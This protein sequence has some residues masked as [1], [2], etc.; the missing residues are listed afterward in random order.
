MKRGIC[1]LLSILM[2]CSMVMPVFAEEVM[3]NPPEVISETTVTTPPVP[4]EPTAT[5]TPVTPPA[6]TQC[7]HSWDAGSGSDATCTAAGTKTFTCTLCGGTKT[8]TTPARGHSYSSWAQVG[9]SSH[10]RSCSVC[11]AEETAAHGMTTSVTK[12]PTCVEKGTKTHSCS[13][14]GYSYTEEVAATGTHAYS[15]WT[16]TGEAHSCTCT[17]CGKVVSGT[18]NADGGEVTTPATCK[19][20]GI[21]MS[22]CT[23]C[24]Y[25]I[26]E[27]IPK[28]TEHTYDSVCDPDCNVCGVTRQVEH[29]LIPGWSKN[30]SGHWRACS[31]KGC[32]LQL[33]FGKHYPGPA[34]TEEEAQLC[35]TCGYTLTPKLNH[36][37][38]FAKTWSSDESGHWYACSG[39]E[40]QEDFKSHDYD[41][42]CDSDCNICGFENDNAHTF[43][44]SWHSDEDGHWFVCVTCGGVVEPK[45]H[46]LPEE[47]A[48]GAAV[49]CSACGYLMAEAAE[50]THTFDNIWAADDSQHWHECSCGEQRD[51][52]SH[53]WNSGEKDDDG[54][55]TYTCGTCQ[56]S[57]VQEA[58]KDP[59]PEFPWMIIF[60]VLLLALIGAIVTLV[61]LLK[62]K[63]GKFSN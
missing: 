46:T 61:I 17:V 27:V 23:T 9:G 42:P 1:L 60:V 30:G 33:D 41:D 4:S 25:I 45:D 63:K 16:A 51:S 22:L 40:E 7:S 11:A 50:H 47:T 29:K 35:L 49:Y 10:K 14:C 28:R 20:E 37:H 52:A 44:G 24:N 32:N 57:Y 8:E 5:E 13:G 58:V 15:E 55:V 48:E 53:N 54:N 39:C 18:H 62:P 12:E 38:D 31:N 21:W 34:A 6:P 19:E 3:E 56:A 26:Y 2:L 43:D 59:A 36:V